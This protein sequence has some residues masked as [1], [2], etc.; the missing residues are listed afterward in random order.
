MKTQDRGTLGRPTTEDV[1]KAALARTE[2]LAALDLA[3][4]KAADRLAA[5]VPRHVD[6]M[7]VI[8][9]ALSC[10]RRDPKIL[11]CTTASVLIATSQIAALGLEPGTALQQAYLVPRKNRKKGADGRWTDV[12]EAT[13]IIGYRGLVLLA[14]DSEG[15][16]CQAEVVHEADV[17][18]ERSGLSPILDHEQ[19]ELA[20][21]GKL[22]GAYAVWELRDG[23]RRHLWWPMARLIHHR[24]RFAPR[25]FAEA[26]KDKPI[27]G[28]WADHLA[29]MCM[30]TVVRAAAKLWPISSDRMRHA[31][32][33]DDAG[34][35]GRAALAFVPGAKPE[36]VKELALSMGEPAESF[37]GQDD[38]DAPP[39]SG[40]SED[41]RELGAEG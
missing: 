41:A 18:R 21:P 2:P 1:N 35:T 14:H 28:P 36:A 8:Q 16:D 19:S 20:D 24:D 30:K 27:V 22:R 5:I 10:A 9:L 31:L 13:A 17:F 26:G 40:Q 3:M 32:T 6:P 37:E 15:I 25:G 29:S 38:G 33:V 4:T 39:D 34:E 12:H 11:R 7:R 23:K